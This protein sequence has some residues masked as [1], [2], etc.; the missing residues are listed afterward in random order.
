MIDARYLDSSDLPAT[1]GGREYSAPLQ[2]QLEFIAQKAAQPARINVLKTS[3]RDSQ[4]EG[5]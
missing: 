3:T 5:A 1:S 2:I 4:V